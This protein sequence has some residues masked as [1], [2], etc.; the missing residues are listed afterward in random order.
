MG[1]KGQRAY[2]LFLQ[3]YNCAQAV[4][5]AFADEMGLPLEVA[6]RMASGLCKIK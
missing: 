3:G 5:G 2:E 4:A 1:E 6:A